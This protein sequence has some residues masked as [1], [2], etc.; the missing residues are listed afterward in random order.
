MRTQH[1]RRNKSMRQMGKNRIRTNGV[2]RAFGQRKVVTG[3]Q[4]KGK[5]DPKVR[6]LKMQGKFQA[7]QIID[8]NKVQIREQVFSGMN[9]KQ[10][11]A[12]KQLSPKEQEKL[13]LS[14]ER[15]VEKKLSRE[16]QTKSR[17]EK[18][19]IYG[20]A[21]SMQK[22]QNK[23]A[24]KHADYALP[25][26][27][28]KKMQVEY[29]YKQFEE[30]KQENTQITDREVERAVINRKRNVTEN[31]T[32]IASRIE[33][34]STDT[35]HSRNH[36]AEK[37]YDRQFK[38]EMK[39][40]TRKQSKLFQGEFAFQLNREIQSI[41]GKE[42]AQKAIQKEKT[43]EEQSKKELAGSARIAAL[44][45]SMPL[46]IKTERVMAQVAAAIGS[47]FAS[48]VSAALPLIAI[49]AAVMGI[50]T[51]ITGFFG[52]L[53]GSW[54]PSSAGL[55]DSAY[56]TNTAVQW[57][58]YVAD[59]DAHGYNDGY[60]S[61][62]GPED[63]SNIT[64]VVTAFDRTGLT[65]KKDGAKGVNDLYDACILNGF[66]DV[67]DEV[68]SSRDLKVGDILVKLGRGGD[69]RLEIYC[70]SNKMVGAVCDE[71]GKQKHGEKG[72][73]TGEEICIQRYS[74]YGWDHIMRYYGDMTLYG[75]IGSDLAEFALSYVGKLPYVYGGSSLVTGA[76]CSGFV[77]AVFAHFG[78]SIPRTAGAQYLAG[79]K[80]GRNE[81][82]W[83]P[84][85]II[86]YSKTGSV[87]TGGGTEEHVVIYVGNGKV[88]GE[89]S[90]STGCVVT[91]WNY[92]SDYVGTARFLPD[93]D[94]SAIL[95][96]SDNATKIWNYLRRTLGCSRAA[97]AGV[98]GN[99]YAESGFDA[100]AI[101][102]NG[103]GHGICQWSWSRWYG[104]DGLQAFANK[105]HK[106]WSDLALQLAF[107]KHEA[108][109][110]NSMAAYYPGGWQKYKTLT[111]V[112]GEGGTAQVFFYS[113][114]YGS[115]VSYSKFLSDEFER[116]FACRSK[117][118]AI[119]KSCYNNVR[120]YP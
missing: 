35:F 98:M 81:N 75:G 95:I 91:A 63:Y 101:E 26:A 68:S 6:K 73:Q 8:A 34:R 24:E 10:R 104:S 105:Y 25:Q 89:S 76:D 45:L 42:N 51:F 79:R 92:R 110:N 49:I 59:N 39:K 1:D 111:S 40:L 94:D 47:F 41:R 69:A 48:V 61:R 112:D 71:N 60:F 2:K 44:P 33:Q 85:D 87:Q 80:V 66:L 115:Y 118:L 18:Q 4:G 82:D 96:G 9:K 65:L 120:T 90:P 5:M 54:D 31:S 99:I 64:F 67:K 78:Y 72:D 103:V 16:F 58:E 119:A 15:K 3:M 116:N 53:A 109:E 62:W 28:Q 74:D 93:F 86:Y 114:E 52:I 23:A 97:A 38:R 43:I 17:H 19:E 36:K 11:K 12:W 70:G 100:T 29:A 20:T 117:R 107:L 7:K 22:P 37:L 113:F 30:K 108:V 46:K 77:Q 21:Q 83:Q 57:A 88:V 106:N 102:P 27:E 14:V 55:P 13:L 84:G 32:D 50:V 56:V